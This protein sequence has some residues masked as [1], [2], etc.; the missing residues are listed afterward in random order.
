[1]FLEKGRRRPEFLWDS[2]VEWWP[3]LCPGFQG[4]QLRRLWH[5]GLTAPPV[6]PCTDPNTFHGTF[7]DA[8]DGLHGG[9]SPGVS[10][11]LGFQLQPCC[12]FLCKTREYPT[13]LGLSSLIGKVQSRLHDHDGLGECEKPVV[14]HLTSTTAK[15]G[16]S[17]SA[18]LGLQP[19]KGAQW[20][21]GSCWPKRPRSFTQHVAEQGSLW[22]HTADYPARKGL[23]LNQSWEDQGDAWFFF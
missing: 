6:N 20:G 18:H 15:R 22:S 21:M 5:C 19:M 2:P 11:K 16:M 3:W 23:S 4:H 9:Q 10:G 8:G 14:T 12:C 7:P 1:M 13:P 17:S